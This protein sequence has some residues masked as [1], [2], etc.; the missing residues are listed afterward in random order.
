MRRALPGLIPARGHG[1]RLVPGTGH[2]VAELLARVAPDDS[3]PVGI[4]P[5][6]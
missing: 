6:G 5:A 4:Y 2:T 1:S 3:S